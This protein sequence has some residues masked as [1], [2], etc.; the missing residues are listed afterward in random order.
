M[1]NEMNGRIKD[2]EQQVME[3][4]IAL[5]G[6]QAKANGLQQKLSV[7]EREKNHLNDQA[8]T[9]QVVGIL[10]GCARGD[11]INK[12]VPEAVLR[13]KE[14]REH[15]T[16]HATHAARCQLIR[17]IEELFD[18]FEILTAGQVIVLVSRE[19]EAGNAD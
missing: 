10:L 14:E 11:D 8:R 3:N 15:I 9:L 19:K 17:E 13:L 18:A 12:A 16:A 1:I 6:L 5:S 7:T 2:L 4:N